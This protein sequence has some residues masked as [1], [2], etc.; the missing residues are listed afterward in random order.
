MNRLIILTG[1]SCVGK[2][3][4][5]A[6]LDRFHPDQSAALKKLVLFNS[7]APRPGERDGVDYHF[8]TRRQIEQLRQH[9]EYEVMEVRGDLQAVHVTALQDDLVSQDVLFD[10][11]PYVAEFLQNNP[12]LGA[13]P[14][15]SIFLA[16]LSAAEINEL[17][18]HEAHVELEKLIAE[19]MR[20][21]LLRRT[22]RQK[23]NQL[24]L[25]DLED[26]E[27]RAGSACRELQMACNFE[28]V[29]PNHDGE[30]SENWEAFYYPL[31][32]ARKTLKAFIGLLQDKEAELAETWPQD[33][34]K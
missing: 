22:A 14:K 9:D 23:N 19:V 33:L 32:D 25:H 5:L 31:G 24:S 4:L 12:A 30:D 1:P 34:L 6:A 28:F 11:N 15:L 2:G 7:R 3:P 20:R 27:R 17:S 8:R 29:L 16:P 13:I 18:S 26:I 10:G 21:K